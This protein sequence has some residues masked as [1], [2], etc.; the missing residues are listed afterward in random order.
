M[1]SFSPQGLPIH[2]SSCESHLRM[3]LA[4]D[5]KSVTPAWT[6]AWNK[7]AV[8]PMEKQLP[9]GKRQ[10]WV[11]NGHEALADQWLQLQQSAQP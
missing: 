1:A 2:L 11:P 9:S 3:M 5:W 7:A 6:P 4:L 8:D 10:H